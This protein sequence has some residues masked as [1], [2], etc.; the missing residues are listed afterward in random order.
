MPIKTHLPPNCGADCEVELL[1]NPYQ[2]RFQAARRQRF[3][4]ACKTLGSMNENSQFTCQKCGTSHISNLTAPRAFDRFLV[5]AGRG[6]GKT[7]IG[8]HAVREEALVPNSIIW[9]MGPTYKVLH[10]STF[11]TLVRLIPPS[12][13]KRWDPEHVELT[14]HNGTLI[15]FRSLEDPERA[16]GPHGV[17]CG[18]F[19]EAA[20][21]PPR[22]YHVFKPTLIKAGGIVIATTTVFGYDWTYDEIE[23]RALIYKEPGFW[24]CRYKTKD[25]PLFR[26]NPTM[27]AQIERD[28]RTMEPDFYAQEYEAE[29]KNASG[30]VYGPVVERQ[31]LDDAGVKRLIPEWPHILP[32][33]KVLVGLDSGADHPFGAVMAVVTEGGIVVVDEYLE[34]MRATSTAAKEISIAFNIGRFHDVTWAANKNE[35]AL[36]LEFGLLGIGVIKA[37]SNQETGIQRTASWLHTGRLYFAKSKVPRTI[38]QMSAYRRGINEKPSGEK[39]LVEEVF[40]LKDELPDGIRYLL[41]AFPELPEPSETLITPQEA[42]R[43]AAFS[44]K[45]RWELQQLKDARDRQAG[46]ILKQG[47]E[48][49]PTGE[50]FNS[51]SESMFGEEESAY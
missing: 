37:E 34:R 50:F 36:R 42:S 12:W 17:T 7:L 4:L 5:L 44:D 45:T 6:G 41:M 40:K 22:A 2:Q 35:I 15:A 9:V 39:K 23:K 3:C 1:N 30:L 49:W 16:R 26:T 13:V 28:Q 20:Q 47:D 10:D 11:P 38:Q 27:M 43:L 33:R 29:R 51:M 46:H 32:H 31:V 19:D 8:A 25:N 24:A 18:W 21:C 48:G 14:L